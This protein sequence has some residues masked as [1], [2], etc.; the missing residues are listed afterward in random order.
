[1]PYFP[2][3][4]AL[5]PSG[6]CFKIAEVT[7]P[8]LEDFQWRVFWLMQII[9]RDTCSVIYV[10]VFLWF[11]HIVSSFILRL[12][13]TKFSLKWPSNYLKTNTMPLFLFGL[14][15]YIQYAVFLEYKH[16]WLLQL[17]LHHLGQIAPTTLDLCMA[18]PQC[19][20]RICP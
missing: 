5:S 18:I 20:S 14:K 6:L 12:R 1:M 13:R 19:S 3:G 17:F 7:Q 2:K 8:I 4:H 10:L 9:H 11:P 15:S 16:Y